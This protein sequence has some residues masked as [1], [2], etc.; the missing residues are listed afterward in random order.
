MAIGEFEYSV[1]ATRDRLAKA[2]KGGQIS[3]PLLVDW[4]LLLLKRK[5][6]RMNEIN[7]RSSGCDFKDSEF[8]KVKS[9]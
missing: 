1:L 3:W 8:K 7:M 6:H 5:L 9:S 2:S 4:K